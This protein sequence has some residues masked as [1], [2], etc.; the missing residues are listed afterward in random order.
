[1]K[2]QEL[3]AFQAVV[4]YR[5]IT[6]A[7][8]AL[9]TTQ[10]TLSRQIA[11]LEEELGC[12]L[13]VR[14]KGFREVTL[15]PAG[16]ALI[17]QAERI[18]AMISETKSV[19]HSA[20]VESIRISCVASVLRLVTQKLNA[21]FCELDSPISP[22]ICSIHSDQAYQKLSVGELDVAV[23][24]SSANGRPNNVMA[25]PL[26]NETLE[27]VCREDAP[28]PAVVRT[29]ELLS[30]NELRAV[31]I[32]NFQ[33]WHSYW[34]GYDGKPF[35]SLLNTPVTTEL[36]SKPEVWSVLPASVVA[37]LAPGLRVCKLDHPAPDRCIYLASSYPARE[38][39]CTIIKNVIKEELGA[40]PGI[41][42]F[43]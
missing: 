23:C 7:A 19:V 30:Q 26:F 14:Q 9:Y 12:Q 28:Y 27:F 18:I 39:Y 3:E 43:Y 22:L 38:P 32:K 10:P 4:Q 33:Q 17:P 29:A 35:L 15:T 40:L 42:L 20:S 13:F 6:T 36:F 25:N 8:Q 2:I 5:S 11:A 24:G 1:M 31:W 34:I 41:Q 16:H 21:H 37:G